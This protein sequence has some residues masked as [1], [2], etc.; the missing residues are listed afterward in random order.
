MFEYNQYIFYA[1]KHGLAAVHDK[2]LTTGN[3]NSATLAVARK[4][5]AYML[6]V[7]K[8]QE[9]FRVTEEKAA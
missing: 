5:V 2:E 3:H 6:A 4:M 1:V 9:A 8:N 7:D